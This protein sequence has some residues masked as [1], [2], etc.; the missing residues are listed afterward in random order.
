MVSRVETRSA[1]TRTSWPPPAHLSGTALAGCTLHDWGPGKLEVLGPE[2]GLATETCS[3]APQFC[4]FETAD[5]TKAIKTVADEKG[6]L[7]VI[8]P[9]ENVFILPSGTLSRPVSAGGG[10]WSVGRKT[11]SPTKQISLCAVKALSQSSDSEECKPLGRMSTNRNLNKSLPEQIDENAG[12]VSQHIG[13]TV[14]TDKGKEASDEDDSDD[15]KEVAP[16]ELLAEF[17]KAVMTADYKVAHKLCQMILIYEPENREAKEFQP[18]IEKMVEMED[19]ETDSEETED[20][21]DTEGS[22][23]DEESSESEGSGDSSDTSSDDSSEEE[24]VP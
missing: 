10:Q 17:L 9:K 2:D 1:T 4:H 22:E 23:T 20:S 14:V 12:C 15:D 7:Q 21:D 6:K 24:D 16:I 19:E 18:L 3:S 5:L 8:G 13:K 11:Y